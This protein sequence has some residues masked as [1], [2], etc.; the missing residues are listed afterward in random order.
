MKR[1]FLGLLIG[2]FV[3]GSLANAERIETYCQQVIVPEI[4]CGNHLEKHFET[5]G[6]IPLE[7]RT[8]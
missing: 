8:S 5:K 1:F 7:C 4:R 2:S 3:F 6:N